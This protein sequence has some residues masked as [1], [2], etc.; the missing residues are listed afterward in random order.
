MAVESVASGDGGRSQWVWR[1][2]Q[3]YGP[4]VFGTAHHETPHVRELAEEF[5]MGTDGWA[6]NYYTDFEGVEVGFWDDELNE[7]A[8]SDE[9]VLDGRQIIGE[10]FADVIASIHDVAEVPDDSD[11][12]GSAFFVEREFSIFYDP[13][14]GL[15]IG[16][17]VT[18]R[19]EEGPRAEAVSGE[20]A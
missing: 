18:S 20:E 7:V 13:E 3:G 5:D 6:R 1:P 19:I 16:V 12:L 8:V 15:I 2:L 9:F 4:F 11:V 14:D 10:P 17:N